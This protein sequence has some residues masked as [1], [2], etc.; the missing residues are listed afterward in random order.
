MSTTSLSED[1]LTLYR[2]RPRFSVTASEPLEQVTTR[3]RQALDQADAPCC[4]RIHFEYVT[5]YLPTEEQHYWSPQLSLSLEPTEEGCLLRGLYGPR[6]EVWTMFVFFYAI[7][8]LAATII[9]IIGFSNMSLG[10]SG[11]VLWL[12]PLLIGLFLTLYLTAYFG[13]RMGQDQMVTLHRFLE[14]STGLSITTR[15]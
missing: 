13:K 6:P 8:G 12:L 7:I 5:L 1:N 3:I 11:M 2:V 15:S 14:Q 4:G 9:A 10:K